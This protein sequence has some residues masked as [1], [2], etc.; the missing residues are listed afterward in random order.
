MKQFL[1]M[2]LIAVAGYVLLSIAGAV[3]DWRRWRQLTRFAASHG[4]T[5]DRRDTSNSAP[6]SQNLSSWRI[7]RRFEISQVSNILRGKIENIDFIYFEQSMSAV[8]GSIAFGGN[9]SNKLG[10]YSQSI[11]ALEIPES[12]HLEFAPESHKKVKVRRIGDWMYF[13]PSKPHVIPVRK[14]EKFLAEISSIFKAG[15][16]KASDVTTTQ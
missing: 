7:L 13:L 6:F 4:Y 15:L 8:T 14:L 3:A 12:T 11:V 2:L 1:T 10:P 16:E 5:L 9:A